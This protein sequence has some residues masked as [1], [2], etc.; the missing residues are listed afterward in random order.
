MTVSVR[1]GESRVEGK[2][3]TD[4]NL[5][6]THG[7]EPAIQ[8]SA[9]WDPIVLMVGRRDV[10]GITCVLVMVLVLIH[11]ILYEK[12]ILRSSG[13]LKKRNA[14]HRR[15]MGKRST[16]LRVSPKTIATIHIIDI[17]HRHAISLVLNARVQR[18]CVPLGGITGTVHRKCGL[19]KSI[20]TLET[21]AVHRR[22]PT[23]GTQHGG[24]DTLTL[25]CSGEYDGC[26][27]ASDSECGFPL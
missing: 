9:G 26:G 19:K 18:G 6:K 15:H 20:V 4:E 1:R 22:T 2:R 17:W 5:T 7:S 12:K 13:V 23:A 25:S 21:N 3:R 27:V 24:R 16:L 11:S 10:F 8:V 14:R